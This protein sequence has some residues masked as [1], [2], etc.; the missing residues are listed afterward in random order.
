MN[1]IYFKVRQRER[2]REKENKH[3]KKLGQKV[4]HRR[5]WDKNCLAR[6]GDLLENY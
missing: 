5:N 1:C 6:N 2:E 3:S 4:G